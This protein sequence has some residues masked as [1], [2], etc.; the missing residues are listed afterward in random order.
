MFNEFEDGYWVSKKPYSL[1]HKGFILFIKF[2]KQYKTYDRIGRILVFNWRV[3]L[4][5]IRILILTFQ[6]CHSEL[7]KNLAFLRHKL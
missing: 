5:K 2:D 7:A 3:E 6:I 4:G 1:P